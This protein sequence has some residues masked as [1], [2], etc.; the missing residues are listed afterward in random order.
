MQNLLIKQLSIYESYHKN[1]INR[2]LHY[3]GIILLSFSALI[4][5]SWIHIRVPNLLDTS[6]AWIV[7]VLVLIYYF[8]LD[9]IFAATLTV[10]FLIMNII[11]AYFAFAGPSWVS[12]EIFIGT[13]IVGLLV[14]FIGNFIEHKEP[15][16]IK[17]YLQFLIG[18][19][20]L[21]AQIYFCLGYR[22]DLQQKLL[23]KE[24]EMI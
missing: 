23:I 9:I 21:T 16:F 19:I 2:I 11:A 5:L 6:L 18:P 4:L 8:F 14:I 7:T 10:A 20:Y 12:F 15:L 17:N 13:A 22:K 24:A 1:F 3:I